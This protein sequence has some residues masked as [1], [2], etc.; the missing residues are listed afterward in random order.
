MSFFLFL[1]LSSFGLSV[2]LV[3][4]PFSS[5]FFTPVMEVVGIAVCLWVVWWRSVFSL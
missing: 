3:F 4:S 1:F 2:F 5:P